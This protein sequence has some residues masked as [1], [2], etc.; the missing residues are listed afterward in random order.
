M[1]ALFNRRG[2]FALSLLTLLLL[3]TLS[4]AQERQVRSWGKARQSLGYN[5]GSSSAIPT[6]TQIPTLANIAQVAVGDQHSVFLKILPGDTSG[7]VYTCGVNSAGQLG[8][9][10]TNNTGSSVN[11][12]V[13]PSDGSGFLTGVI[14]VASGVEAAHTLAL[15][16]DG[17]VWAWGS[18]DRGQLGNGDP[19]HLSSNVP[20]QVFSLTG[21]TQVACGFKFSIALKSDGT[22]WAWGNNDNNELGDGT[23]TAR[24][25][26]VQVKF[27][28][29]KLQQVAIFAGGQLPIPRRH[30]E[31]QSRF[32]LV[33]I[34]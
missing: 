2:F 5:T 16:A 22:V 15:K 9:G 3:P 19:S 33:F 31:P 14:Q 17:T 34:Q 25:T 1:K 24:D 11:Q 4:H 32:Q 6:P 27:G 20:L 28:Q 30:F 21:V 23:T 18:N 26:A 12:V 13:D 7:T 29:V 10:N 8:L